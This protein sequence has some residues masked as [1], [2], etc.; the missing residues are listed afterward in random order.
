MMT[1][2]HVLQ[3]T[4]FPPL[5]HQSLDLYRIKPRNFAA[6][7]PINEFPYQFHNVHDLDNKWLTSVIVTSLLSEQSLEVRTRPP[8]A[9][10]V[11]NSLHEEAD[12]PSL[13]LVTDDEANYVRKFIAP[14]NP[15]LAKYEMHEYFP[16][17]KPPNAHF[18]PTS[19]TT[20]SWYYKI[21]PTH[22]D[23]DYDNDVDELRIFV[24]FI[25]HG[26]LNPDHYP[27]SQVLCGEPSLEINDVLRKLYTEA[28]S[29]VQLEIFARNHLIPSQRLVLTTRKK[30]LLFIMVC[31][32]FAYGGTINKI[33]PF[34]QEIEDL[35][36]DNIPYDSVLYTRLHG[37]LTA[38]HLPV[39]PFNG[40]Y[41]P[42]CNPTFHEDSRSSYVKRC[43]RMHYWISRVKSGNHNN[44]YRMNPLVRVAELLTT[45][46]QDGEFHSFSMFV[47]ENSGPL[48]PLTCEDF[49]LILKEGG[50][51]DRLDVHDVTGY[52]SLQFDL[53]QLS[54]IL[55]L[56]YTNKLNPEFFR[57]LMLPY[58][59]SQQLSQFVLLQT[60]H[61]LFIAVQHVHHT[62]PERSSHFLVCHRQSRIRCS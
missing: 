26:Y 8:E 19:T 40:F 46:F 49:R 29:V 48:K 43:S 51:I 13:P 35:L 18:R 60:I 5:H 2:H 31:R 21:R 27:E 32:H 4:E 54:G 11:L 14:N 62:Q 36:A 7:V 55:Y 41:N 28:K 30:K 37:L 58:A 24:M 17:T 20:C 53:A 3:G 12:S 56:L 57:G 39:I 47:V 9:A 33:V 42:N 38:F 44:F 34:K 61:Y 16:D 45:S 25:Y 59:L 52:H 22:Q 1:A 50:I 6:N 23:H 15:T 10:A